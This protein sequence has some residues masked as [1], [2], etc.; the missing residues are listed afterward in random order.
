MPGLFDELVERLAARPD[1][2]GVL[3]YITAETFNLPTIQ[4]LFRQG[5]CRFG[6]QPSC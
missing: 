4:L 2:V 5:D 6:R 3:R 1:F